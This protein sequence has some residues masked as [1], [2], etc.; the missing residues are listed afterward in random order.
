MNARDAVLA[1]G[2]AH[3][4]R[5]ETILAF[6]FAIVCDWETRRAE[7]DAKPSYDAVRTPTHVQRYRGAAS[8][9]H[10]SRELDAAFKSEAAINGG[11]GKFS[12]AALN[13]ERRGEPRVARRD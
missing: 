10:A 3:F 5:S 4:R 1:R 9:G 11:Y 6:L 2:I 12:L 7:N 8:A 13:C